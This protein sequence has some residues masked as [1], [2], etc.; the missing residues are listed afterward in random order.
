MFSDSGGYYFKK[1]GKKCKISK[2]IEQKGIH[3][4]NIHIVQKK[5]TFFQKTV[6]I[7]LLLVYNILVI[8]VYIQHKMEEQGMKRMKRLVAL[9]V[10]I[11]TIASLCVFSIPVS[12][13][14]A[15]APAVTVTD[16]DLLRIEKL[17][18]LGVID[19]SY[20]PANFV[21]RRTMADII[22]RY[23]NITPSANEEGTPFRDV[24]MKD[25]SFASIC[26][27]YNMGVI[28]GDDQLRFSPDRYVTYDQALVFIINAIGHK[29]FAVREGG[30]P[31]GYHRV[32]IK[33][34][35][36]KGLAMQKGTDAVHFP[37]LYKMLETALDAAVVVPQYYGD[38]SVTY[39]LSATD[40]FLY[41]TYGIRKYHG[42]V[43]GNENTKLTSADMSLTDEQIEI[44]G[45]LYETPGYVYDYFLGYAVNYYVRV[46]SSTDAEMLY[47]EEA[48]N[49]NE[50]IKIDLDDIVVGKTTSDRI[51]Y[52][53]EDN[54]REEHHISFD[55][56]FDVIY[57]KQCWL[58]Y[59]SLQNVISQLATTGGYV[60]ALDNNND[61][62]IDILFVYQYTNYVVAS[63]DSYKE[64]VVGENGA[65][66]SLA[67]NKHEVKYYFVGETKKRNFNSV[68]V[69]SV[70]SVLKSKG[71]EQVITVYI[72]TETVEGKIV[73]SQSNLGYQIN[74]EW[75]EAAYNYVADG[76]EALVPGLEG[77]FCLDMN[78]EIAA[79]T[80][81]ATAKEGEMIGMVTAIHPS[82]S[83]MD[84]GIEV[85]IFTHEGEFIKV[86]VAK[87]I[88]INGKPY[89]TT[90]TDGSA[91][92][93]S[94][95]NPSDV[96]LIRFMLNNA[97]ELSSVDTTKTRD[98]DGTID[99]LT[100]NKADY[101]TSRSGRMFMYKDTADNGCIS[102]LSSDHYTIMTI[103]GV[104]NI[105]EDELYQV[106]KDQVRADRWWGK[107]PS[108]SGAVINSASY[109]LYSFGLS[110]VTMIN[111][112]VF[113]LADQTVGGGV[114]E[115]AP[116]LNDKMGMIT[117]M[118]VA[119]NEDY[120]AVDVL[121]MDNGEGL[122]LAKEVTYYNKAQ[123]SGSL[124]DSADL[125]SGINETYGDQDP[126]NDTVSKLE[127]GTVLMYS[128]N[129]DGEIIS[130]K[131]IADSYGNLLTTFS[132]ANGT[133]Y[134][135]AGLGSDADSGSGNI[136]VGEIVKV[137]TKEKLVQVN[138]GGNTNNAF[139]TGGSIYVYYSADDKLA[140]GK[141]TDMG[142]G[143][144]FVVLLES[145]LTI[146][147]MYIFK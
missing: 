102:R 37:D 50:V 70:L 26:T 137:D 93:E 62:T 114:K 143:N 46:N 75:Y 58:G 89:D 124:V 13:E 81:D 95:L 120:E 132:G 36:L 115:P 86:P 99:V 100:E 30:Y 82:P 88:I 24:S 4:Q 104:A 123:A 14:E 74:D 72:S 79:Y 87:K 54:D 142:V 109:S 16:E 49:Y 119:V 97:G 147:Q 35:M 31:T 59:G 113:R 80:K 17:E 39:T 128:T 18:A 25:S 38:G 122:K 84:T 118:S 43:T 23:M 91:R 76:Y 53:E 8:I 41:E 27:L 6:A 96:Y 1:F 11:A 85:K 7:Y 112:M 28:T 22:V 121:Y 69:G 61:G 10:A 56:N 126:S 34:N 15:T 52:T 57:N 51:Y 2:K 136:A 67:S 83:A 94:K 103:P 92:A 106:Y 129:L 135:D 73:A 71:T 141:I 145:Y 116:T 20:D 105:A 77:A 146:K 138:V 111:V 101:M 48:R 55:V 134:G 9:L 60:E 5:L 110:E 90:T 19:A 45:Q 3:M 63:T 117:D 32:A 42:I 125:V 21:T 108:G 68:T 29:M 78:G 130:I 65:E 12:A 98:V 66:L 127:K 139:I 144:K 40:T 33:H 107:R 47:I 133:V 131:F 44:D 64:L 140:E